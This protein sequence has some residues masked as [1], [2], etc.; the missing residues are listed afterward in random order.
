[1]RLTVDERMSIRDLRDAEIDETKFAQICVIGAGFAGLV[2]SLRMARLGYSV[3][4]LESGYQTVES[5]INELN[6]ADTSTTSYAGAMTGRMRGLGGTSRRWG[7][8]LLPL[9][10]H[11]T[12]PRPHLSLDGWPFPIHELDIYTTE[13]ERLFGLDN[14]AFEGDVLDSLDPD[15]VIPRRDPDIQIR[16]PKWPN[17]R[18]RNIGQ[19]LRREIARSSGLQLY[20]G[21]TA[22]RLQVDEA[23]GRLTSVEARSLRGRKL[24]VRADQFLISAGTI[25]TTRLLLL[26]NLQTQYRA[27]ENCRAL[28]HYFQDHIRLEVGRLQPGNDS[29][30]TRLF[31]Y[32]YWGNTRRKL[33]FQ[34][35]DQAQD[36]NAVASAYAEVRLHISDGTPLDMLRALVR[37]FQRHEIQHSLRKFLYL[38]TNVDLLRSLGLWRA[39]TQKNFLPSAAELRLDVRIEQVPVY[40]NQ[41]ALSQQRDSF[42]VPLPKL[43]WAP[44]ETDLRTFLRTIQCLRDFWVRAGIERLCPVIWNPNVIEGT[45]SLSDSIDTSHPSGTTRMGTIPADSVVNPDLRC[46]A[47]PNIW[48]AS[49][50]AFPTSGSANPTFT[51]IQLALRAADGIVRTMLSGG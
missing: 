30:V 19:R 49:A 9:T 48:I 46:H 27:F 3:I 33:Y 13:I 50:S 34:L 36:I 47:V 6:R 4:L 25:E 17:F 35:S 37:D 21:A 44:G 29:R 7:G 12:G 40:D 38:S 10:P 39:L 51:I 26:L 42:D 14:S 8:R 45:L 28:G 22:C 43:Q 23:T 32:D 24:Q 20:L 41:I 2:A 5:D 1:M 16:L 15:T 11:D 31:G 18:R